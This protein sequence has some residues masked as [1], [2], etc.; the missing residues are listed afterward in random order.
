MNIEIVKEKLNP[1]DIKSLLYWQKE[2]N[3]KM[4]EYDREDEIPN[5]DLLDLYDFIMQKIAWHYINSIN[6]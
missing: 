1:N 5:D 3:L 2:L 4:E 6:S